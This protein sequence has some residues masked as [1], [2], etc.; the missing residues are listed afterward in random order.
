[1]DGIRYKE[2][3]V[4]GQLINLGADLQAP[5]H[6]VFYCYFSTEAVAQ[7]AGDAL[8]ARGLEVK[9]EMMPAAFLANN[10]D[11]P[12]PWSVVAESSDRGLVPDF[13]RDTVD[14]CE[15]LAVAHG[16]SY[17]GWEA[18]LTEAEAAAQK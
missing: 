18:G 3:Q 15:A 9:V 16:G 12:Y 7:A 6:T 10:P 17:D 1:M 5:R 11:A 14:A 4:V 2:L 8:R 13:L